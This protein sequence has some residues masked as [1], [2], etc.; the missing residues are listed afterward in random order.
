MNV[1]A[2]HQLIHIYMQLHIMNLDYENQNY[3]YTVQYLDN[4]NANC[5]FDYS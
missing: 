1:F 4:T 3:F 2:Y 5:F